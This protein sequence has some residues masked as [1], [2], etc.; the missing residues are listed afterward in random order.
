MIIAGEKGFI[1]LM[2]CR[3]PAVVVRTNPRGGTIS[4]IILDNIAGTI[5]ERGD[6]LNVSGHEWIVRMMG[7]PL[8]IRKMSSL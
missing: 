4:V 3:V 5:W 7:E 1:K 6:Q 2:G 8:V